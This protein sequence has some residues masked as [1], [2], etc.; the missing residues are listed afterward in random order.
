MVNILESVN[1]S[2]YVEKLHPFIHEE[3]P[4]FLLLALREVANIQESNGSWYN[5]VTITP[6]II[7]ALLKTNIVGWDYSSAKEFIRINLKEDG[8][9]NWDSEP[10]IWATSIVLPVLFEME[11]MDSLEKAKIPIF[12]LQSKEG[13]FGNPDLP[14]LTA[15]IIINLIDSGTKTSDQTVQRSVNWLK[16]TQQIDDGGWHSS[17]NY[18][19]PDFEVSAMCM[20][21]LLKGGVSKEDPLIQNGLRY[22]EYSQSPNGSWGNNSHFTAHVLEAIFYGQE[23]NDSPSFQRGLY[24]LRSSLQD[25]GKT[26]QPH[27]IGEIFYIL[28]NIISVQ[29]IVSMPLDFAISEITRL[30][31]DLNKMKALVKRYEKLLAVAENKKFKLHRKCLLTGGECNIEIAASTG[32]IFTG[33]QF[34]SE[35]YN[36]MSLKKGITESLKSLG[37][38]PFFADE[39]AKSEHITCKL[40]EKMQ[41]VNFCIFDL[42]D[43]NPNVILELGIAYGFGKRVVIIKNKKSLKKIPSDLQGIERIEYEDPLDLRE[44]ISNLI[45]NLMEKEL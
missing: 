37:I 22:L 16:K 43:L 39:H 5:D 3:N 24:F 29:K 38:K 2:E 31:E 6:F 1:I 42:S 14:W 40:C 32:E 30:S 13:F 23:D 21:A 41:R 10:V 9:C 44:K 34:S 27:S 12:S 11:M 15:R 18:F 25:W 33:F 20:V 36:T 45:P 7:R 19:N 4:T 17:D 26:W 35:Y 28:S 8:N